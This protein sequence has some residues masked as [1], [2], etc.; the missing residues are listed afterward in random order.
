MFGHNA[1]AS[2]TK[3]GVPGPQGAHTYDVYPSPSFWI[4]L[5]PKG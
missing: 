1:R 3:T 4:A 2:G 5:V